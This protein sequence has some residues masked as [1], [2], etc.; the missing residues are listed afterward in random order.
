MLIDLSE[1]EIEALYWTCKMAIGT[2]ASDDD[3]SRAT[4][5]QLEQRLWALMQA[6][7]QGAA[8]K[9]GSRAPS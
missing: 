7:V 1:E 9:N 4:F 5:Q 6:G 2:I 3:S 8:Q